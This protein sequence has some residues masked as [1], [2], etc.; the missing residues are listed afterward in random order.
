MCTSPNNDNY[1]DNEYYCAMKIILDEVMANTTCKMVST[2]LAWTSLFIVTTDN[3]G[4]GTT[5]FRST[6]H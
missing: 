6:I 5:R 2:G 3:G 4:A 1:A